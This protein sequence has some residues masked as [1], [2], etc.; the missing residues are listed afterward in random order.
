MHEYLLLSLTNNKVSSISVLNV[1]KEHLDADIDL[2][3]GHVEAHHGVPRLVPDTLGP[4][5]A[6]LAI[7]LLRREPISYNLFILTYY[8]NFAVEYK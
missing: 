7:L 4:H 2:L 1:D 8:V 3:G 6:A 5:Q